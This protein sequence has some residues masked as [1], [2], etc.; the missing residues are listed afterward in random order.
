MEAETRF[1]A[2]GSD[3]HVIVVDGSISLL[4]AAREFIE[5]LEALWSRFR[6]TSEISRLNGLAGLPVRVAEETLSLVERALEGARIA[7]GRYDPTVLGAVVRAGYD[8]SFEL[9]GEDDPPVESPLGLGHDR[10]VV[11]RAASTVSMPVGV[12]FD[13]GGIGK[14]LAA[15]LVAR[16]LRAAGAAGVCVNV[17]GDLRVEGAAPGGAAWTIAIEHPLRPQATELIGL[18]SGAVATSTRTRR[19]WG[20]P[21]D[22]RHHLIDPSTGRPAESGVLSATV[23]AA[24]AWQAEVLAKAAFVAGIAEGLFLIASTEADGVVIDDQGTVY[25]SAGLDRFL[26]QDA[27]RNREPARGDA[28]REAS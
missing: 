24:E 26:G 23:I 21:G 8:R 13:P 6:P 16:K 1:R 7:D 20:P 11:D 25:P 4:D 12:G 3:V 27:R 28:V 15:D 10:I 18:S 19:A 9:I 14:G 2:M 5:R 17:G 22:R